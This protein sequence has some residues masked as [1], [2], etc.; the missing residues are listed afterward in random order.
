M[1]RSM[2]CWMGNK[3]VKAFWFE[4]RWLPTS[5]PGFVHSSVAA[6]W[7]RNRVEDVIR[8]LPIKWCPAACL[9]NT[10]N[11][12]IFRD[13][14]LVTMVEV[15]GWAATVPVPYRIRPT[16][17]QQRRQSGGSRDG[18]R[19]IRGSPE[20]VGF[21]P[22]PQGFVKTANISAYGANT[23]P[24]TY[25]FILSGWCVDSR[26]W[27]RAVM[28][29]ILLF[30]AD[31]VANCFYSPLGLP[32]TPKI[33]RWMTLRRGEEEEEDRA[34]KHETDRHWTCHHR[35][36]SWG[37]VLSSSVISN[38]FSN[39]LISNISDLHLCWC[40]LCADMCRAPEISAR[41]VVL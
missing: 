25:L 10:A 1:C 37:C 7:R 8:C 31:S 14:D 40:P 11:L 28:N 23:P 6:R 18:Q 35:T 38:T 29:R 9:A 30:R 19:L 27:H 32:L 33:G 24:I 17:Q 4:P 26:G 22:M 34:L 12:C 41:L 21:A 5:L 16:Q 39:S 3:E 36:G 2:W 15:G 13:T 20:Q